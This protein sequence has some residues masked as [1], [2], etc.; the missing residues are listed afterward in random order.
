MNRPSWEEYYLEIAKKVSARS[1]CIRRKYGAVI[2]KD[3]RIVSTGYN[4]SARDEDNCCDTGKCARKELN[5]PAGER[6]ELC[7]AVH[8]EMNA[9]INCSP[10]N[11]KGSTIYI[12]GFNED[13]SVASAEP[14]MMCSRAIKNAKITKLSY[15][16]D[17]GRIWSSYV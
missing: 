9:I 6:Y 7:V 8:A 14:C 5:V 1:T 17:S 15:V 16:T 13:G 10:E 2:V 11:L 3:G 12:A 4:G